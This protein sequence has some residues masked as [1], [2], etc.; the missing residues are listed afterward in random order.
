MKKTSIVSTIVIVFL[1]IYSTSVKANITNKA[2]LIAL[3]KATKSNDSNEFQIRLNT[4]NLMDKSELTIIELTQ[5]ITEVNNI[6]WK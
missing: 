4:I 5:L 1:T 3:Q 2:I 6:K